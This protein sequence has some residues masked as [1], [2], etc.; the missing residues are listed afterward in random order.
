LSFKNGTDDLR[1]G[2]LVHFIKRL[3][4]EGCQIQIW[5]KDVELGRLVGSNRRFI[6]D[7]VPHIGMLLSTDI[8]EVVRSAEVVVIGTRAIN[9][10]VLRSTLRSEQ[11]IVD[12]VHL[13]KARRVDDHP[14]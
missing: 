9:R 6:E 11:H 10:K 2:P 8:S 1:E 3:L 14:F 5:D 13:E 12:L 4:G 7:V